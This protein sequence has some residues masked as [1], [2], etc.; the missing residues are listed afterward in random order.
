[1]YYIAE[2]RVDKGG[3]SSRLIEANSDDQARAKLLKIIDDRWPPVEGTDQ[4]RDGVKVFPNLRKV[5][6]TEPV[7]L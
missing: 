3:P 2:I 1:M 7:G 5:T 4:R 6:A